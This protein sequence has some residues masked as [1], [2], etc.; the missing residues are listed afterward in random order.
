M[1][2]S[3]I[4]TPPPKKWLQV[5][6]TLNL[7]EN[8][9]YDMKWYDIKSNFSHFEW[10]LVNEKKPRGILCSK[11]SYFQFSPFLNEDVKTLSTE[12]SE[13]LQHFTEY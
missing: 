6:G 1:I 3:I 13:R 4:S 10:M 5:S 9:R 7:S 11:R 12:N 2:T 8:F